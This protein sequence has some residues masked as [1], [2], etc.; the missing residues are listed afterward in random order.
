MC[1]ISLVRLLV[2]ESIVYLNV[3]HPILKGNSMLTR[4]STVL[5]RTLL[6]FGLV[7][8]LLV[9]Q[10][11]GSSTVLAAKLATKSSRVTIKPDAYLLFSHS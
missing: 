2:Y 10:I 8:L 6:M 7:A 3:S 5:S 11:A 9:P 1:S 4:S